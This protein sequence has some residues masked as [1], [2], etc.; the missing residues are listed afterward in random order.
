MLVAA[1]AVAC[2]EHGID[3]AAVAAQQAPPQVPVPPPDPKPNLGEP[4]AT[5]ERVVDGD[6]IVALVDG[7]EE[8][9]RFIG[10]DT[11]ESVKQ[12]APV[13][14]FGKEASVHLGEYLPEG[15][16]VVLVR[17]AEARDRYDR[18]LAYVYRAS[19]E[20]FVNLQMVADGYALPYEYPP[21]VAHT[22]DFAAA[23]NGAREASRGIW[24]ACEE[25]GN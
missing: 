12:N 6:T 8:R 25:P 16:P 1:P 15:S 13:E 2:G 9:V 24:A 7:A 23:S 4:N 17:D 18:L 14:C 19:D 21:N 3:P 20:M 22:D 11:P 5:V 10:I